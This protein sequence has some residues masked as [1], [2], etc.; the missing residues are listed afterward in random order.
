MVTEFAPTTDQERL[1]YY[2][3]LAQSD[4]IVA[5]DLGERLAVVAALRNLSDKE[6]TD[7][8]VTVILALPYLR[9]HV[10]EVLRWL[11]QIGY[12]A[13]IHRLDH[14]SRG[15]FR[16]HDALSE[17]GYLNTEARLEDGVVTS[18]A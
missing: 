7:C 18:D 11:R 8:V 1:R 17:W 5:N 12:A 6:V 2:L 10:H 4:Q 15:L 9:D 3:A 14:V 16:A 13:D